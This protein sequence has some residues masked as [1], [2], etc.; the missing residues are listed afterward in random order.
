MKIKGLFLV[1]CLAS[2]T[3]VLGQ[4]LKL[5]EK[6]L[7]A[8]AKKANPKYQVIYVS[9]SF[10]KKQDKKV[11]AFS[12]KETFYQIQ[13][14]INWDSA[15]ILNE[16]ILKDLAITDHTLKAEISPKNGYLQVYF[17]PFDSTEVK[18]NEF[19][20][21]NS[22]GIKLPERISLG[23]GYRRF[24][25]GVLTLPIKIYTS[26]RAENNTNNIV[27]S[28][29]VGLYAGCLFGRKRYLKLPS[30]E[31]YRVYEY[32]FSV[33]GFFGVSKLDINKDNTLDATSFQGS[34]VSSS[35]GLNVAYH[36]KTFSVF[37]ASGYDIPL[38]DKAKDW[39][40]KNQLWVGF[41]AGF[42]I[43]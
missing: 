7:V 5:K 15:K 3:W 36:Y 27:S 1:L 4:A 23:F 25:A 14:S 28:A 33:N 29:N 2:P 8:V 42:A 34:V 10:P 37:L 22:F 40:F 32:G 18:A 35:L 43:L 21:N 9:N 24:Q 12:D 19:L 17:Y 38:S 30:E 16:A 41:G 31:Q 39:H 11:F 26:S 13:E 6:T 20:K